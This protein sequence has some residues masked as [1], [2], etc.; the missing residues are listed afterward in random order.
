MRPAI[1]DFLD[2]L[3]A[4][5]AE[6]MSGHDIDRHLFAILKGYHAEGLSREER[7]RFLN[8]DVF[9]LL[10]RHRTVMTMVNMK[11]SLAD[12]GACESPTTQ[13]RA[14]LEMIRGNITSMAF[15]IAGEI[16]SQFGYKLSDET[17][18]LGDLITWDNRTFSERVRRYIYKMEPSTPPKPH[19][20]PTLAVDRTRA[21]MER[22]FNELRLQGFVSPSS[23]LADWLRIW[24]CADDEA[25]TSED[26]E[27]FARI[28]WTAKSMENGKANKRSLFDCLCLIA[29]V[30]DWGMA[31]WIM[32]RLAATSSPKSE[33]TNAIN[34]L[35]CVEGAKEITGQDVYKFEKERKSEYHDVLAKIVNNSK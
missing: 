28:V 17:L 10:F 14:D 24:R 27:P 12:K 20:L 32:L 29:G 35:F 30:D 8:D 16:F 34:S 23:R 7:E 3:T 6:P 15:M 2:A 19:T 13:E 31:L 9:S 33:G 1:K 21:E 22:I 4:N 25:S 26:T 18:A 11:Q 5:P